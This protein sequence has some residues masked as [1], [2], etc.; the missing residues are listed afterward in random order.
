MCGSAFLRWPDASETLSIGKLV[1]I[2][3]DVLEVLLLPLAIDLDRF[4][5][6]LDAL[7]VLHEDHRSLLDKLFELDNLLFEQ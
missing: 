3:S 4:K 5:C 2:P 7:A 6:L 1:Q